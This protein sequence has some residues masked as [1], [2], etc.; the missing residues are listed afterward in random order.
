MTAGQLEQRIDLW[1]ARLVPEWRLT[2]VDKPISDEMPE[3]RAEVQADEDYHHATL[4]IAQSVL[5]DELG[6]VDVTIV[7]ELLHL[8][9]RECRRTFN[10]VEGQVHRD[11]FDLLRQHF[12]TAEEQLVERV[13]RVVARL[14]HP[15]G[16]DYGVL[17]A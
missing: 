10:L 9:V 1:R 6:E 15:D 2:I 7:H 5:A 12:E 14:E 3:C 13:A 11:V 4:Y 17:R 8:L 16:L